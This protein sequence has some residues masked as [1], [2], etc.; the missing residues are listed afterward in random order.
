MKKT[1]RKHIH[2]VGICGVTMAPLA[3]LYKN[4][5]WKVTGSDRAFFP[6]MSTYLARNG[7][8]IMPGF[9]KEHLDPIPDLVLVMAFITKKN[10]EVIEARRKKIPV[11]VYADVLPELIEKEN[12]IVIAG[13]CGKTSTTALVTWV[14]EKAG[15]NPS[16]MIGGLPRNFAHGIRRTTSQWSVIEGDEYVASSWDNT[17]RFFYYNPK[18]LIITDV[19]WDHM[20]KYPTR[21]LYR[22]MFAKLAERVP[23]DGLIVAHENG[24]DVKRV[25]RRTRA[26]VVYYKSEDANGFSLPFKGEIWRENCA[27]AI[28]LATHLGMSKNVIQDALQSFRGIRRRQEVRW[29][30]KSVVVIDDNAHTPIKVRGGLGAISEMYPGYLIAV[31]YEPGNRTTAALLQNEYREC[32]KRA[33][34]ILLP[35]VSATRAEIANFNS[36][37]AR[38]LKKY[39]TDVRYIGEDSEVVSEIKKLAQGARQRKEKLAVV[40]MSQKGFRGMVEE[41]LKQLVVDN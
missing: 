9:K 34:V 31:I 16:F 25:V 4:M 3:V 2:I 8:K 22:A 35:R 27:A 15:Y 17:P 33:N 18:Y 37:L 7:V 23:E 5:G 24:M 1:Q 41:T 29:E 19:R 21:R 30:S 14:L 12:S 20:D 40:F 13:D 36:Y 32:F 28:L 38:K 26:Q 11:K 6:P 39:Y 10:P